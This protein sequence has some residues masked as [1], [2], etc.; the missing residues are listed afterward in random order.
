MRVA[1]RWQRTAFE[2]AADGQEANELLAKQIGGKDKDLGLLGVEVADAAYKARQAILNEDCNQHLEKL[3]NL[4]PNVSER[5]I[6]SR[7][8]TDNND[9]TWFDQLTKIS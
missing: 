3:C 1:E 9:L 8:L 6:V 5:T 2:V 4:L 7:L